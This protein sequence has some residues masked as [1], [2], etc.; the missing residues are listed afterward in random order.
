MSTTKRSTT[1][2][3]K[4]TIPDILIRP[5][6]QTNKVEGAR[7]FLSFMYRCASDPGRKGPPMG[8]DG[9]RYYIH[10]YDVRMILRSFTNRPAKHFECFD[11]EYFRIGTLSEEIWCFDWIKQPPA[12]SYDLQSAENTAIMGYLFACELMGPIV[13][14]NTTGKMMRKQPLVIK[15]AAT[16]QFLA[17]VALKKEDDEE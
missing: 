12:T 16:R 3:M 4:I 15:D 1:P 6:L 13:K 2:F 10:A 7:V 17:Y 8:F 9:V 11:N 14:E 5:E